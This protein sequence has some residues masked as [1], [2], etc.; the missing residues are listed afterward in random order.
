MSERQPPVRRSRRRILALLPGLAMLAMVPAA[1]SSWWWLGRD[2]W[3]FLR[4]EPD[5]SGTSAAERIEALH[6]SL[7]IITHTATEVLGRRNGFYGNPEVRIP[8]PEVLETARRSLDRIG[9]AEPLH[10]LDERMNRAAEAAAPRARPVVVEAIFALDLENA[11]AL[12]TGPADGATRHLETHMRELIAQNLKPVVR[13]SLDEAEAL[14]TYRELEERMRRIPFLSNVGF[15]PVEHVLEHTLNGLF[16]V[17]AEEEVRLRADPTGHG[18]DV[19]Q[20]VFQA[21]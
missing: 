21:L 6:E 2:M 15:D 14:E 10:A 4:G 20:R 9:M 7:I 18:S 13:S 1:R 11:D 8:L 3:G 19:F 12:L 16:Q 17:M 5:L